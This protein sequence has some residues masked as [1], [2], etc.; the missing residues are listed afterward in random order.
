[1]I[2]PTIKPDEPGTQPGDPGNGHV[3]V[4]DAK[5]Q[6]F[7]GRVYFRRP[8][9]NYVCKKKGKRYS[10]HNAVYEFH[11]G[12]VPDGYVIHH[13]HR[14][15]DG[16][17]DKDENNI[18]WLRLMTPSEHATYHLDN[19]IPVKKTC[20]WCGKTFTTT[21][22]FRKYC[23]DKCSAEHKNHKRRIRE[24]ELSLQ[25]SEQC[26]AI[27]PAASPSLQLSIDEKQLEYDLETR[28]CPFCLTPFTVK[29]DSKI[30]ICDNP[31]CIKMAA[32]FIQSKL[33]TDKIFE[34]KKTLQWFSNEAF[35][36]KIRCL[37]IDG[38]PCFVA[39]SLE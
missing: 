11:N 12:K 23:N 5:H 39:K 15:P 22:R 7:N 32:R 38:E 25:A 20:E 33:H 9:G 14:N 17:F 10:L 24:A 1:M 26:K 3:F 2:V 31:L 21:S 4:I 8:N 16:T 30:L 18:E 34:Q 29:I 36:V 27:V 6:K 19:L 28:V 35:G 37:F 13:D